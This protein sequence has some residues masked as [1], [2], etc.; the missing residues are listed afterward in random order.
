[1]LANC[2]IGVPV[3]DAIVV[4]VGLP[5]SVEK[6][7]DKIEIFYSSNSLYGGKPHPLFTTDTQI[8]ARYGENELCIIP[9]QTTLAHFIL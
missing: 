9:T 5:S 4:M 8:T 1:M 3:E 2:E 6:R 7:G